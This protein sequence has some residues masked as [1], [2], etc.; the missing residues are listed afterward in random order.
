MKYD[1]KFGIKELRKKLTWTA[2][3]FLF[4][5][6]VVDVLEQTTLAKG[7]H[8]FNNHVSVDNVAGTEVTGK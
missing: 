3:N 8:A 4:S 2:D 5:K 6:L 1:G 7:V